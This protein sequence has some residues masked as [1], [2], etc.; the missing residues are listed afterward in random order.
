MNNPVDTL[1]HK[2]M[3]IVL[4]PIPDEEKEQFIKTFIKQYNDNLNDHWNNLF[5]NK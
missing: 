4:Q 1:V 3:D 2:I 5:F